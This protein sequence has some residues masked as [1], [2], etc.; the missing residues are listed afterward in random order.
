MPKPI[1]KIVQKKS[2]AG[3]KILKWLMEVKR[4]VLFATVYLCMFEQTVI[5]KALTITAHSLLDGKC[6]QFS[7]L[8]CVG[9][10]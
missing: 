7:F 2:S 8:G 5:F 6:F 10:T 4:R 3:Y 1:L 9:A